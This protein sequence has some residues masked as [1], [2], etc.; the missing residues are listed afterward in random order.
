MAMDAERVAYNPIMFGPGGAGQADGLGLGGG[1]FLGGIILAS[2]LGR[3][4]GLLG[5]NGAAAGA[6]VVAGD[7]AAKVVA[8]Q[9]STNIIDAIGLLGNEIQVG[10][11]AN[12]MNNAN[13]FRALDNQI[14]GV[15]Q[16][17]ANLNFAQTIQNMNNTQAIQNQATANQIIAA[18]NACAIKGLIQAESDATR[19][20]VHAETDRIVALMNSNL[21]DDL[22]NE[23]LQERRS[24]DNREIEI[25][26]TQTNQQTQQVLQNQM[27][28]QGIIFANA[29]N[30][31]GDQVNRAANSVVN[32]GSGTVAGGQTNSQ[33]NTKVNS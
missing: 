16:N 33:A 29:L 15:N 10:L 11:N 20:L 2:L 22:R 19:S 27:Q 6:D 12:N 18:E 5:G 21:I 1:G 17:L 14:C 32:V 30:A 7:I 25:N 26:V 4:N 28:Q 8:L 9:N 23:L 3:G 31:L 24:R 13:N